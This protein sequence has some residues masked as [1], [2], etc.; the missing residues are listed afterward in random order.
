MKTA[1][2]FVIQIHYESLK[3]EI[4]KIAID[5]RKF[6]KKI[7]FSNWTHLED[8]TV[9]NCRIIYSNQLT[10]EKKFLDGKQHLKK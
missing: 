6:L 2:Y 5:K 3:P 7:L 1:K 4:F 8:N 9:I 10:F